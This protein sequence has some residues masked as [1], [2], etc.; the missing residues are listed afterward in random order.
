MTADDLLTLVAQI[1]R[2]FLNPD[3]TRIV[4]LLL[5]AWGVLLLVHIR[6]LLTSLLEEVQFRSSSPHRDEPPPLDDI[7][8]S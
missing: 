5:V 6:R 3:T 7:S 4:L 1:M 2:D 8:L